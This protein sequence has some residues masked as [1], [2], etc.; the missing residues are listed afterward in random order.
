MKSPHRIRLAGPWSLI[1]N[2]GTPDEVVMPLKFPATWPAMPGRTSGRAHL[3]RAFKK[4]TGLS[5][6]HRVVLCIDHDRSVHECSLN[7]VPLSMNEPHHQQN[8]FCA[9][10]KW[11]V[12]EHLQQQNLLLLTVAVP[13]MVTPMSIL[14]IE[15]WLEIQ[16]PNEGVMDGT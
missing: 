5:E 15:V 6:H 16:Q 8:D 1:A 12:L 4:P 10:G 2:R 14:A 11:D 13:K 3:S 9:L 7:N